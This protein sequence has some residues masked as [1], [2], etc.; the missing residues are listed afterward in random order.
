M[1]LPRTLLTWEPVYTNES[2]CKYLTPY[3]EKGTVYSL[4]YFRYILIFSSVRKIFGSVFTN[5][6]NLCTETLVDSNKTLGTNPCSMKIRFISLQ[7]PNYEYIFMLWIPIHITNRYIYNLKKTPY[8]RT[9]AHT[10]GT[11]QLWAI[12]KPPPLRSLKQ[13]KGQSDLILSF[14]P[15]QRNQEKVRTKKNGAEIFSGERH[16]H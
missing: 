14:F 9:S 5:Q 3:K 11:Q 13:R 2:K 12:C 15:F 16:P 8:L 6:F 4:S 10:E 1:Q 7:H